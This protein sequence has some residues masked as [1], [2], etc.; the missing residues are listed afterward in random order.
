M[1]KKSKEYLDRLRQQDMSVEYRCLNGLQRTPWSINKPVLEVMRTAWDSG[2]QWAGLP[3]REDLPLPVYPF[4]KDPQEMDEAEKILFRDWSSKR[5]R[6]YQAN[7]KSMSRRIQVERTLQLANHYAKYDEF[8]FVWQLDFRSRKY[9]VESFMSPQVADWGKALIGFTY[10]FP[11]KDAGDADWLAIHGANLFG[12]DKVSFAE[13]IQWAWES[14]ADIVKVAENPLDYMWW[15]QADKPWQFLGW[16]MEWYGLLR[17]GWGYYTH[18]PCSADGSCNG[19]QHLSAILLD[20]HGGKACNLVPSDAPSDIYTDVAIRAEAVVKQEAQQGSEIAKKCLEFGITRSLTK[21]PVMITPY[22]GTQHAC[23]EYIQDAI[24][25]RI[26]KKGDSNPFGDDYFEASL[27]LSRHIWQAINE[28][29]SSARQVMD[30]V[31]T[32]GSHYADANKH[33]EWITPTNFLV[34]QPYLNTKKRRIETHIDGSIVRLS[35]QQE[36]DDVNRSRITTGSSPNF[37]HSLDAAALTETVVRCMDGGM[38]DFAMVH[39]SYGTHSPNMP[40]LSQVLREAFVEMYQDNDVLQQLRDHAC[41]TVGDNTLP[42]PPT[43]GTL[44]LSKVLE[45]QYFFA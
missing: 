37:I 19:L 41:Y 31:K 17:E 28:T 9:P 11:I 21:R 18:L 45:S 38:T 8:Y 36:M 4:D 33:M 16:C 26:E 14:E 24:A 23:R 22:S 29:I 25:D 43:K 3:P 20:S 10:G 7:G 5:N 27:Y 1:K 40:V 44:D 42:Q 2:E 13:R 30:Y 12:N 39:D 15:T 32:I 35:Y 6:I 34:V